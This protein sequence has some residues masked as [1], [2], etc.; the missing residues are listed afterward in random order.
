MTELRV[1][2]PDELAEAIAQRATE[3]GTTPHQLLSVVVSDMVADLP[4]DEAEDDWR[5]R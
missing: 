5:Y 2:L 4:H 1:E 3:L